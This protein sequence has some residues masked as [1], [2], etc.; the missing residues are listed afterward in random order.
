[1]PDNDLHMRQ[2]IRNLF[3]SNKGGRNLV[4]KHTLSDHRKGKRNYPHPAPVQIHL[5]HQSLN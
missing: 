4:E 3:T 2:Q 1:M 5:E